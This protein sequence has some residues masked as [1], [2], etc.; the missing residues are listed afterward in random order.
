MWEN[1]DSK[2]KDA[3]LASHELPQRIKRVNGIALDQRDPITNEVIKTFTSMEE[4]V[5]DFH[6]SRKSLK[7]AIDFGNVIKGFRFALA[8]SI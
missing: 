2:I 5:R 1:L 8:A 3:Y 6:L 7:E 4:I